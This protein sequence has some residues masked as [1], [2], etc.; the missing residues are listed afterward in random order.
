M[1]YFETRSEPVIRKMLILI[2]KTIVE[3]LVDKIRASEFYGLLTDEVTDISNICQL[4]SFIK[5][6]DFDKGKSDTIFLDCSDLLSYS[7][8]ASPNAEA[9]FDCIS[10]K[11]EELKIEIQNLRAFVSDGASVMMGEKGGAAQKIRELSKTMINFHCICHSLA[12]ACN[13]TGDEYKFIQNVEKYLI[14]LW[15]FFKNSSKRLRIYINVALKSRNFEGLVPKEQ[16][17]VVK[18]MKKAC[19]TRW[20]SLHAGVDAA[21]EEFGGLVDALKELEKVHFGYTCSS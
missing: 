3:D 7:P 10:K 17:K 9:I 21:W 11:F 14:E 8:I 15:K 2:A 12:L 20:L 16:K 1:K 6:F 19:R 4:L 13:D 5:L 18:R